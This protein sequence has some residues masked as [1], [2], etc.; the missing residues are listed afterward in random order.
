MP[1]I[2][3][4]EYSRAPVPLYLPCVACEQMVSAGVDYRHHIFYCI[5]VGD[6]VRDT[7]YGYPRATSRTIITRK[8]MRKP[9]VA[10]PSFPFIWDSG[11]TS[12]TTTK[13]I[14]PAAN[15]SA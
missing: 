15:A 2:R 7:V 13:T 3:V 10:D 6:A 1:V 4:R 9:M 12:S 8:P 14:A 11:M 5:G